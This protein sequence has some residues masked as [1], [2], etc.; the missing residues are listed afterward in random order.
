MEAHWTLF[1]SIQPRDYPPFPSSTVSPSI[2]SL[3]RSLH[4]KLRIPASSFGDT[5][6]VC[7][8]LSPTFRNNTL[9]SIHFVSCAQA[10]ARLLSKWYG[11]DAAAAGSTEEI[12]QELK[13]WVDRR[14]N[15]RK[16]EMYLH[17][18]LSSVLHTTVSTP[19]T[20]PSSSRYSIPLLR[21]SMDSRALVWILSGMRSMCLS[22]GSTEEIAEELQC[23][24]TGPCA[25]GSDENRSQ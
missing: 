22:G 2:K 6:P 19:T 8:T 10:T 20:S 4:S 7:I 5:T 1:L 13:A 21:Q 14:K 15:Y 18:T 9:P 3:V 24:C 23:T 16:A 17:C 25:V 11:F 12:A